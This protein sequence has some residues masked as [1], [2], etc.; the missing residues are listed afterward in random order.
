MRISMNLQ[1]RT[2]GCVFGLCH[3]FH[4]TYGLEPVIMQTF[5]KRR[6]DNLHPICANKSSHLS[7][8]P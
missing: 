5:A 7:M 6:F 2:N 3:F 8:N 1:S 4:P